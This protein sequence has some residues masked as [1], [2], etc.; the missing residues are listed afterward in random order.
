MWSEI[1]ILHYTI[2]F[3]EK[4]EVRGMETKEK[5]TFS[6]DDLTKMST[7]TANVEQECIVTTYD[8]VKLIL[9]E[10]ED[11]RQL[12]IN[13]WNYLGMAISFGLPCLTAD[14][15]DFWIFS[16]SMIQSFFVLMTFL[17]LI[18]TAISIYKRIKNR[19]KITINYCVERIKGNK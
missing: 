11:D 13:W 18:V 15:K 17:L 7:L 3:I 1:Q 16:A 10:Y 9:R 8:K 2:L 19:D 5:K 4:V 6:L 12:A 14:F